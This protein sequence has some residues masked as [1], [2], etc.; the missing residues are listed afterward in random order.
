MRM[1]KKAGGILKALADCFSCVLTQIRRSLDEWDA[2]NEEKF[3]AM[4]KA[5]MSFEKAY[6]GMKPTE[7]SKLANDVIKKFTGI[8]D[9]YA[10]RKL[11]LNKRAQN[12]IKDVIEFSN[13]SSNPLKVLAT[14]AIFG[15]HLDL[16]VKDIDLNKE[17]EF[18]DTLK[19]KT[20]KLDDFDLFYSKMKNAK[21]VLYILDNTGE[22]VFDKAFSDKL[23]A[24]FNICVKFA[25]RS[26]PILNDVTKND[27]LEVGISPDEIIDSGSP[28]A[29]MDMNFASDDFMKTWKKADVI[30]SK[31]QGNFEGLDD[32]HDERLFFFLEAKC[33]V[34]A[35]VLD[36]NVGD[37]ILAN[38]K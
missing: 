9:L 33:P 23:K 11:A 25:V 36:V 14:A 16:G 31:G 26:E 38:W 12:M 6:F 18:L 10:K 37:A 24:L 30:I 22:V 5:S 3:E 21:C 13:S 17:G 28:M 19:D 15:N 1:Y 29:G 32:V 4:K 34:I 7:L 27:A 2:S 20:L 8:G 35:S